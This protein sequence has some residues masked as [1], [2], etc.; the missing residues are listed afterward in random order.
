MQDL[1]KNTSE[2]WRHATVGLLVA[3]LLS[4]FHLA[5]EFLAAHSSMLWQYKVLF[6]LIFI[7]VLGFGFGV[8]SAFESY[9]WKRRLRQKIPLDAVGFVDGLWIDAV[10]RHEQIIGAG[11][12]RIES[13]HGEGFEVWGE[14]YEVRAQE[15]NFKDSPSTFKGRRGSL[16][17]K[18]GFAY[19]FEGI[20]RVDG[21]DTDK[22][23]FGVAYHSFSPGELNENTIY[24][25]GS[26]LVRQEEL[27]SHVVGRSVP[28]DVALRDVKDLLEAWVKGDRV[29][30]FINE[31]VSL[32]GPIRPPRMPK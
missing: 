12:F 2:I 4:G 26:Y 14:S 6:W 9:L 8:I 1:D 13:S 10:I 3:V 21:S 27:I 18:N 16:F 24:F 28:A 7:A 19:V 29:Q 17:D 5:T 31:V 20:A 22:K 25:Q 15:V 23:H 32:Q 11:I 30:R